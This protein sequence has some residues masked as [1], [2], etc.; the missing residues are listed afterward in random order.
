MATGGHPAD[1]TRTTAH[2]L[3]A[4]GAM[5]YLGADVSSYIHNV[6]GL[7]GVGTPG[8]TGPGGDL[9]LNYPQT[10][11]QDAKSDIL[12]QERIYKPG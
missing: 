6:T 1:K 9:M 2:S 11:D 3:N 5:T 8:T 12:F 10:Y 7:P 4:P